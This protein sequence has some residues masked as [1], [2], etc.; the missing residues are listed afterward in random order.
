M[1]A[2]GPVYCETPDIVTSFPAEPLNTISN[3]AVVL[4]LVA[5]WSV[6]RTSPRSW[7]LYL[8]CALLFGVGVGST[9]WHGLR[10]PITLVLDAL[11][12]VLFFLTFALLWARRLYSW[13]AAGLFFV[14][15]FAAAVG[16]MSLGRQI[17][18]PFFLPLA[19]MVIVFSGWLMAKTARVS[20]PAMWLALGAVTLALFALTFRSIDQWNCATIPFGTHF[21]WH[22]FLASAAYTGIQALL[23]LDRQRGP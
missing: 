2:F 8:L 20:W 17:G 11:P 14:V 15:F 9:L 10:L 5:F 16:S 3:I 1:P 22:I 12:G 23:A 19:P 18:I 13:W 7:D 6:W 4:G 21:L